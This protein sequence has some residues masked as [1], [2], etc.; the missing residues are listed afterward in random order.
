MEIKITKD[1]V[2]ELWE[3]YE[4]LKTEFYKNYYANVKFPYNFEEFVENEITV[5]NQCGEYV[6]TSDIGYSELAINDN[7]CINCMN[8]GYGE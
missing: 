2:K 1:N 3:L 4:E 6:L 7:I 5:C 8:N